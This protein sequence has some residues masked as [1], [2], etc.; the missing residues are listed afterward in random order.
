MCD[1]TGRSSRNFK[2]A[3]MRFWASETWWKDSGFGEE[4]VPRVREERKPERRRMERMPRFW[5]E[6]STAIRA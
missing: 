1:S 6:W 2:S 5:V 3:Q 4:I